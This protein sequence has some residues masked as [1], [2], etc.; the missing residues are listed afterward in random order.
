MVLTLSS[1]SIPEP[2]ERSIVPACLQ[3]RAP[4]GY[5]IRNDNDHR[6]SPTLAGYKLRRGK[7]YHLKVRTQEKHPQNWKLRLLAP[8]SMIE[9]AGPDEINGDARVITFHTQSPA[10]IEPWNS[11]RSQLTTLP[12][13][14]DF[15]DGREPYR[16][17][18][19]VI[20][21]A[22]RVRWLAY[23]LLTALASVASQALFREGLALPS[24]SQ[25]AFL[26]GAWASV[27]LACIAWDQWKF[28]RQARRLLAS[29]SRHRNFSAAQVP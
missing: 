19:P 20:L 25:L 12:V 3:S 6:V 26:G 11:F 28:Y 4:L 9:P 8:R 10:S 17:S 21:L 14:L 27:V 23:L 2:R 15:E 5:E 7:T 1:R 24:P 29:K 13:H 16:F 18:V 22:S